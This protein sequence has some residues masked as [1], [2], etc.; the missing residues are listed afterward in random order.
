MI[1]SRATAHP[2]AKQFRGFRVALFGSIR[3]R[4]PDLVTAGGGANGLEGER[5][6][7]GGLFGGKIVELDKQGGCRSGTEM[8]LC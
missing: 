3:Y 7:L 2:R 4:Q 6:D 8:T 5:L 1:S